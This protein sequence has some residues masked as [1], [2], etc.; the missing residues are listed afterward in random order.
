MA[1]T[2]QRSAQE[3]P[4][5]IGL[6]GVSGSGKTTLLNQLKRTLN[7][8]HFL[9]YEG[10]QVIDEVTPGGLAQFKGWS[11]ERQVTSR[12][13]AIDSVRTACIQSKKAAIVSGH[14]SF[15]EEDD[16]KVGSPVITK[17]DLD[18]Y[19]HILYL[20]VPAEVLFERR[21]RDSTRD[22]PFISTE[23]LHKWQEME[24][25][26]LRPLCLENGILF[27]CVA[28]GPDLQSRVTNLLHEFRLNSNDSFNLERAKA[29][30]DIIIGDKPPLMMLVLD[31][32]KTLTEHDTGVLFWENVVPSKVKGA[33]LK[34]IFSSKL[35]Y[36][37]AAFCQ[38]ALLYEESGDDP[39]FDRICSEV[40]AGVSMY[41]EF[42]CLLHRVAEQEHVRAVVV[43]CG[44]KRVW[45]KVLE[46]ERL[47]GIVKIIGGGRIADGP[48]ITGCVKGE[49]VRYLQNKYHMK[50][51]AFGD[52]QLDMEMLKRADRGIVVVGPEA[53]R[54]K[55][56]D[57]ALVEAIECGGVRLK[58]V[59]LPPT[60]PMRL[61][62][63]RLPS[64]DITGA[65]F[66][67]FVPFPS[68]PSIQLIHATEKNAAKLLMTQMRNANVAGPHLCRAHMSVGKYLAT[69]FLS[70]VIGVEEY[71]IPHVLG[72]QTSGHQLY[73][74]SQTL[75]VAVMRAGEPMARG[76]WES[77]PKA[78]FLHVKSP[79]D[80]KPHHVQ[81]KVTIILVDSVINSGKTVAEFLGRIQILHSTVRIVVV[82]G[83]VQ[84][85]CIS[86]RAL[87]QKLRHGANVTVVALR[88]SQNKYTGRG[89]TDTGN[90]LFNTTCL[91]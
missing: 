8:E 52:S 42:V 6:Y 32:D 66:M 78:S 2:S 46:K 23:D 9:F 84:A 13:A 75:I 34:D 62:S 47:S 40:A 11:R 14:F 68:P 50:V 87:T 18:T 55:S 28:L 82:A 33:S 54:S 76:V 20:N 19:T 5:V 1:Q 69:E 37:Y 10:S 43:T 67:D 63:K 83:V 38:A 89:S 64:L 36:S 35:G 58:Q 45:E 31:A 17:D 53:T 27:M 72:H 39:E 79:E 57:A 7:D 77:F 26:Q 61:D 65:D 91:P 90:R 51:W 41:P 60:T 85:E 74:E 16:E 29:C 22:R 44:I 48:V 88:V 15:F 81:G 25:S 24:I 86:R 12:K 70:D 71:S 59:V 49:L 3:K 30:L 73:H 80:V 21:I 4:V 56:M